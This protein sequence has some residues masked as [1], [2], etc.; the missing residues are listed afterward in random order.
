[1]NLMKHSLTIK[2]SQSLIDITGIVQQDVKNSGIISGIAV[3]YSPH[4]TAGITI[5]ENADPDVKRD[6]IYGFEKAFPTSDPNYRHYE[7]NSHSHLKS[8][9]VGA[10]SYLIIENGK[11]LLGQWQNIYF[12]EFDGPRNRTFYVKIMEG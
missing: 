9:T 5:N 1:M 10:S 4:T 8:S 11:L 2:E 6:L 12:C 7:G 3:I